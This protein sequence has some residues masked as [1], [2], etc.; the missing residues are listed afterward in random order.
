VGGR[1]GIRLG[2]QRLDNE[3]RTQVVA[4]SAEPIVIDIDLAHVLNAQPRPPVQVVLLGS[5]TVVSIDSYLR[6]EQR[7]TEDVAR[8]GSCW[9]PNKPAL[10]FDGTTT[11]A[12][13]VLVRLLERAGWDARWIKNWTGGREFCLDPG[14]PRTLPPGPAKVFTALHARATQLRGAGSWDIFAWSGDDYLFLESK[15]HRSSDRLNANQ[16]AWLEAAID[17]GFS[18]NQ[19]AVVEYHVAPRTLPRGKTTPRRTADAQP[20][21]LIALLEKVRV[22]DRSERI[23]HRDTVASFGSAAIAPMVSWLADD[24][25]RRFAITVLASIGETDRQGLNALHAHV[26]SAGSRRRPR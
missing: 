15:K 22:T 14:R 2:S 8:T 7:A 10:L 12:E 4:R 11:W 20:A 13:Y 6:R 25:F 1:S 17:E 5:G 9:A 21:A 16:I 18:P 19:F 24:E 3:L 23:E 26:R